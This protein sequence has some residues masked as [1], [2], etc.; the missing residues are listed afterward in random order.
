MAGKSSQSNN[1]GA[2]LFG[3]FASGKDKQYHTAEF[4]A[5]NVPQQGHTASGGVISE[6][7]DPSGNIYKAHVF[8][9]TGSF[10]VSSLGNIDSTIDYLVVG[11]G[12]GGG[13]EGGGGG[14]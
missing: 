2:D 1:R 5:R 6:Y 12:G 3:N 4:A 14:D 10:N 9:S 13:K 11:G 8:T 7:I